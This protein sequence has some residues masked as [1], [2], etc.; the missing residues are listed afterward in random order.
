MHTS[1]SC[2]AREEWLHLDDRE[3]VTILVPPFEGG[4][5]RA[6]G[7]EIGERREEQLRLAWERAQKLQ[8]G[9]ALHE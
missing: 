1:V 5:L 3:F 6:R 7:A 9:P 8:I 4:R 2:I